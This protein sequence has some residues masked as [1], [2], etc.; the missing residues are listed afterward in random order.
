MQDKPTAVVLG[1]ADEQQGIRLRNLF[2]TPCFRAY[3]SPDVRGV[4]L[5]GALKNV[6]A[7][8]AGV[9]DGLDFGHNARA[10]L[11]TRGLAEMARLGQ[12][13]GAKT[14]TFMG[15]SGLGDLTLTCA[16]DLS[17]NRQVGLR[18]GRGETLEQ[19]RSSMKSV[20]EGVKTAAAVARLAHA[21]SVEMPITNAMNAVLEGSSSPRDAVRA[22]MSRA[23]KEEG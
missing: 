23:L 2:S 7:I 6:I 21:K 4:E 16:G 20:A 19:I 14:S 17:R 22:L 12:S 9:S 5:S 11:I 15:L 18:L 13:M 8:A 1:C 10:A 3:S